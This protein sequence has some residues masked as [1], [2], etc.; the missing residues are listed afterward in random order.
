MLAGC[1]PRLVSAPEVAGAVVPALAVVV[2]LAVGAGV[3]V[4]LVVVLGVAL[5]LGVRVGLDVVLGLDVAP[6]LDV[7]AGVGLWVD[8]GAGVEVGL[9]EALGLVVPTGAPAAGG[10]TSCWVT[11]TVAFVAVDRTLTTVCPRA[12]PAGTGSVAWTRVQFVEPTG[13]A[14]PPVQPVKAPA[15]SYQ[16]TVTCARAPGAEALTSA[17]KVQAWPGVTGSIGARTRVVDAVEVTRSA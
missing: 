12:A 8:E 13:T 14:V 17:A 6:E 3:A 10:R 1:A 16:D 4:W 5:G 2:A 9:G 15:A 11:W 7:G